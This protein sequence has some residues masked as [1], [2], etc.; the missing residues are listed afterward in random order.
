MFLS[1]PSITL[2]K[3][4]RL[5][6]KPRHFLLLLLPM[7]AGCRDDRPV[8]RKENPTGKA[9]SPPLK[10]LTLPPEVTLDLTADELHRIYPNLSC[11]DALEGIVDAKDRQSRLLFIFYPTNELP[12]ELHLDEMRIHAVVY[13]SLH[14][15]G[16]FKTGIYLLPAALRG[17]RFTGEQPVMQEMSDEAIRKATPQH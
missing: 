9:D 4:S 8:I 7:V 11:T 16:N 17:Q 5:L 1:F 6:L 10:L 3:M 13:Q 2:R 14:E 12:G 15:I